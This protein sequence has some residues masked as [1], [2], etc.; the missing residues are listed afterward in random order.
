LVRKLPFAA[1]PSGP[2]LNGGSFTNREVVTDPIL[3]LQAGG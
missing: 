1:R 3:S 2:P